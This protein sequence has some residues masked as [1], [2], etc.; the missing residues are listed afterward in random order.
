MEKK[1]TVNRRANFFNIRYA[2]D[3]IKRGGIVAFPTETVYGL[4]AD[5]FN[6]IAVAKVFEI[7]SRPFFDP[8][9][10]HI[11]SVAD[12]DKL[13]FNCTQ[14]AYLLAKKFWPGPLTLVLPKKKQVPGIVTAGLPTVAVRMPGHPVALKLVKASGCPIAAP[15]ANKFSYL[16]PTKAEHVRKH[17]AGVDF[18]LDGGKAKI[19]VESTVISLSGNKFR[20]LRH[21]AIPA[22]RILQAVPGLKLSEAI[23]EPVVSP[24]MLKEHYSPNKPLFIVGGY[25]PKNYQI[26]KAALL[27]FSGENTRG[28][29]LIK[30]LT[31]DKDLKEYAANLFSALHYLEETD[32]EFIAVEPVPEQGIGL[33]IMDRLRKAAWKYQKNLTAA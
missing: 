25:F 14:E 5:A 32:V 13:V 17:L 24:G 9:I 30:R 22:E 8:L 10:V 1:A 7:K 4:G 12:L 27:S 28:Y 19:G 33:A 2:S 31:R 21:G 6:P 16:S 29:R 18:I 11:A 15:S 3:T 23:S 20:L 26:K